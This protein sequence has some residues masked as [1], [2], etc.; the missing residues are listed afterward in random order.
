MV[1]RP[2]DCAEKNY[3]LLLRR[4]KNMKVIPDFENELKQIDPNFSIRVNPQYPE[5]A[6]VYWKHLYICGLPSGEIFDDKKDFY[7]NTAGLTHRTRPQVL[8]IVTDYLRRIKGEKGFLESEM[9]FNEK[10]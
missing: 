4:I 7:V 6:G 5:M 9:S 3:L 1:Q 10:E 2:Q 8:A